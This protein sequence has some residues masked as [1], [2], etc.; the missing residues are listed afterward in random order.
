MLYQ[1]KNEIIKELETVAA[2]PTDKSNPLTDK[3]IVRPTAI[4]VTIEMLRKILIIFELVKN[5][6]GSENVKKRIIKI[7]AKITPHL[8]KKFNIFFEF[9]VSII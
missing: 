4:I 8:F 9:N 6:S 7:T 5:K 3:E 2:E 1:T